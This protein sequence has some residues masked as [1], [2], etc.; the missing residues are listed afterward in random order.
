MN[1]KY[2][3]ISVSTHTQAMNSRAYVRVPNRL[4]KKGRKKKLSILSIGDEL[5]RLSLYGIV[6]E[7]KAI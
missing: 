1:Y 2:S 6:L 4:G 5:S 7:S 3:H